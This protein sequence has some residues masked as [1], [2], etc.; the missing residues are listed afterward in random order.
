MN[1]AGS[2]VLLASLRGRTLMPNTVLHTVDRFAFEP[3]AAWKTMRYSEE[4]K[5]PPKERTKFCERV[6]LQ[7]MQGVEYRA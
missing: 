2:T 3:P 5:T 4:A 1:I 7:R 6:L